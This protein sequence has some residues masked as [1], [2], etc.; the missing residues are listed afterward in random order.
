MYKKVCKSGPRSKTAMKSIHPRPFKPNN[1]SKKGHEKLF[2]T[3]QYVP[4]CDVDDLK[5]KYI[6]EKKKVKP[7]K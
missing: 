1:P 6:F 3:T 4:E 7:W 5:I 2:Q